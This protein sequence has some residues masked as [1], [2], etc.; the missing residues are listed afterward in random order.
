MYPLGTVK[1]ASLAAAFPVPTTPVSPEA[2]PDA[3]SFAPVATSTD[4][5]APAFAPTSQTIFSGAYAMISADTFPVRANSIKRAQTTSA[6][7]VTA[8]AGYIS[9]KMLTSS[10]FEL[11]S[12]IVLTPCSPSLSYSHVK[13]LVLNTSKSDDCL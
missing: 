9:P 13:Y 12:V 8:L 11:G 6:S 7:R 1:L 10:F 3:A 4:P 2:K 5:P